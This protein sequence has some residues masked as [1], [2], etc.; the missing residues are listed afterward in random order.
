VTRYIIITLF[1]FSPRVVKQVTTA[2]TALILPASF[3]KHET[4]GDLYIASSIYPL[5]SRGV[6]SDERGGQA[7]NLHS[8]H[9]ETVS[10]MKRIFP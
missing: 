6:R 4:N 5:I 9:F 3:D 7:A 10:E 1:N 8:I 2:A